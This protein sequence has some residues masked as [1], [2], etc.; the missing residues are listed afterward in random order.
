MKILLKTT[1]V[2]ITIM[3][4]IMMVILLLFGRYF[5]AVLYALIISWGVKIIIDEDR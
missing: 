5:L 2:L 3:N 1:L 4:L